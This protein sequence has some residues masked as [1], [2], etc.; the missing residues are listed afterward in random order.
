M[1]RTFKESSELFLHS[2]PRPHIKS[3]SFVHDIS[4]KESNWKP[5]EAD[6]HTLRIEMVKLASEALKIER[7]EVAHE[8]A[9]EMF[10][11]NPFKREQLPG[12]SS[13]NNGNVT[14]YRV[15][16][17]IDISRGPMISNTSFVGNCKIASTHKIS[18]P[19]DS[20]NLYRIQGVALPSGFTLSSFAFDIIA[21]RA[22]KLVSPGIFN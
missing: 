9:I 17:H 4:L 16:E 13:K 14:L 3:G 18:S 1:H 7:L 20:H 11:D 2:F 10:S 12:I 22:K 21:D 15:G 8:I 6:L 5:S 19:G